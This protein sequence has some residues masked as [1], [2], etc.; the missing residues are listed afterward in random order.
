MKALK[1]HASAI[2]VVSAHQRFNLLAL[3]Q[4]RA[5]GPIFP[6]LR[7]ILPRLVVR[8]LNH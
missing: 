5:F 8:H 6:E 2:S 1:D 4:N 3:F 7:L